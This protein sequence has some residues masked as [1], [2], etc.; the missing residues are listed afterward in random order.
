[1]KTE[2]VR[3]RITPSLKHDVE[4]VLDE[5]GLTF[6]EAIE[7]FLR[8][9]KLNHGIPFAIKIPNDVT[10]KTF[11]DTDKDKNLN[12]YETADEMFN[13]LGMKSTK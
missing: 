2:T 7:L 11:S 12:K 8:Q 6:S 10:L 3:A 4:I 13:K 5:L 1:M 9:I